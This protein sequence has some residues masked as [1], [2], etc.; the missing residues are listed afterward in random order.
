MNTSIKIFSLT[1]EFESK[2]FFVTPYEYIFLIYVPNLFLNRVKVIISDDLSNPAV[3]RAHT[4]YREM[5]I[6][7]LKY[8]IN[9]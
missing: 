7:K 9:F 8:K 3:I 1:E 5:Q 4:G 6:N 2:S